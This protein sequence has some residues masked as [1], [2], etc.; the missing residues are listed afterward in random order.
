MG[1]RGLASWLREH[2]CDVANFQPI[3]RG[4][5]ILIDGLGLAHF[6][7]RSRCSASAALGGYAELHREAL[8]FFGR[9]GA[10]GLDVAVYLDGRATRLKAATISK[11]R[12]NRADA[13]E[14][15]MASCLDGRHLCASELPEPL[16]LV[17]CLAHSAAAADVKLVRS[18]GEADP[19]L[20]RT[21]A[22]LVEHF[23]PNAAYVLGGDSDFLLHARVQY[24]SFEDLQLDE[25]DSH[26]ATGGAT[27][28]VVASAR[29]WTRTLL[30]EVSSLSETRL[31]EWALLLGNDVTA[32]FAPSA[33]GGEA[34]AALTEPLTGGNAGTHEEVERGALGGRAEALRRWMQ[35]RDE[36]AP[37]LEAMLPSASTELAWAVRYSRALYE[38]EP[39]DA[40]AADP[41]GEGYG[42]VEVEV[43]LPPALRARS[44]AHQASLAEVA[45]AEVEAGGGVVVRHRSEGIPLAPARTDASRAASC[46]ASSAASH[47]ASR[48]T[49]EQLAALQRV[50]VNGERHTAS[51]GAPLPR[52]L[53]W[54]DLRIAR[55]YESA[56][57]TLLRSGALPTVPPHLLFDGPS[58]HAI[59][60]ELRATEPPGAPAGCGR[61]AMAP[62]P[63]VAPLP[64]SRSPR[65]LPPLAPLV[66]S[67]P[68]SV[69]LGRSQTVRVPDCREWRRE[70]RGRSVG[71]GECAECGCACDGVSMVGEYDDADGC[72]YCR[73]CW[74]E[75]EKWGSAVTV[76]ATVPGTPPAT[77]GAAPRA[78]ECAATPATSAAP[79]V[80]LPADAWREQILRHVA[81]HRV[82]VISG[83][84]G[85]GKSSRVPMFLLEAAGKRGRLMVA[86]PRR[87]AAHALHRRAVDSGHG[88]RVGLRM[89]GCRIDG[90]KT[91]LWYVTTGYLARLCGHAPQ[92]FSSFSHLIIDECHERA[93]DADVLCLLCRR[94]LIA[95][96]HLK[97][98]L[99]SATAHND[100]LRDYYASSLGWEAV[101]VPLHVGT[102]RFPIEFAYLSEVAEMAALPER[103][104]QSARRLSERCAA[105]PPTDLAAGCAPVSGSIL[106]AQLELATWIVRVEAS[107]GGTLHERAVDGT[108]GAVLIFVPGIAGVEEL[109]EALGS[110]PHFQVVP[111]HSSLELE[112][113]LAAFTPA[114]PGVTKVIAATN[115]AES[116]LTLP[117]VDLVIDTGSAS[118]AARTCACACAA[119]DGQRATIRPHRR[120]PLSPRASPLPSPPTH[121]TSPLP[122]AF[123]R[124]R[125]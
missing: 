100:L 49:A 65:P 124:R 119:S 92:A 25:G 84:T 82:S 120:S 89:A 8:A 6:L 26:G 85:C 15:L 55:R 88:E 62:S 116:S 47:G 112:A 107:Q 51:A 14:A 75:Y 90:P 95:H 32:P 38:N 36:A 37:P 31:V 23:G 102:R 79:A 2:A 91:R 108:H 54:S 29:V 86:Q 16:L 73:P 42:D 68:R 43:L 117:D 28:G 48:G 52:H 40:F 5:T 111:I 64:T 12:K 99:M 113:Q 87:L 114:P 125:S 101:S 24:I 96:P 56:C 63:A 105:L 13:L 21:C 53:G 77:A 61:D 11:R 59:V 109:A 50:A 60:A 19:D 67:V 78:G 98:V 1:V 33:F 18:V 34:C 81:S 17:E 10:A 97:L 123:T 76:P 45:L 72:L 30:A 115:A 110:S 83:E 22:T 3:D 9:L 58:F 103:L 7:L 27:G 104:R 80:V 70:T 93:V 35:G 122:D 20:A 118:E 74:R 39:L 57:K 44:R 41:S 106:S 4:A 46:G 71:V 94:L 69:P 121:P 66:A